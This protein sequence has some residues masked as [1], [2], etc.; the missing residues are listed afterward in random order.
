M[1]FLERPLDVS[2]IKEPEEPENRSATRRSLK[3]ATTGKIEQGIQGF[4][5]LQFKKEFGKPIQPTKPTKMFKNDL[6]CHE[7]MRSLTQEDSHM[8]SG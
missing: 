8:R 3:E 6:Y 5:R 4:Q 2:I 7:N 1:H